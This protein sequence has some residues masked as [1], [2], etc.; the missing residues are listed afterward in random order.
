[1]VKKSIIMTVYDRPQIV[2]INTLSNLGKNDL[3]DVEIVIVDDGSN[4]PYKDLLAAYKDS[5]VRYERVDTLKD[6]PDTYNIKGFNN[7][8]YAMNCG[9][10]LA[11]GEELYF[12]S[13][14][15]MI[16]PS[17]LTAAAE[18]DLD[19][20][21][22]MP[23]VVDMDSN[24]TYLGPDRLA[25]LGWF[26]G[27]TRKN[28]EAVRWDEEYLK[29]IACEDNDF[30]ARLALHVGRFVCETAL[31]AWHQS[32]PPMAYSDNEKGLEINQKYTYDKWGCMPWYPNTGNCMKVERTNVNS[33]MVLDVE[34]L[35]EKK[36]IV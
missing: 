34:A 36:L 33:Q 28:I 14:D 6:R 35:E 29:G 17:T 15:V 11:Q 30:M 32:H 25:P 26:F 5:P 21:V 18:M 3:R 8:A 16:P 24:T 27:T 9:I 12:M 4:L 22:W 10:E 7:P 1:V 20:V 19:K 23:C 13:S 2:L 31:I